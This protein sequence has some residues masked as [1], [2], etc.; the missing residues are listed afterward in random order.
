MESLTVTN[1][2]GY[3]WD[4]LDVETKKYLYNTEQL[5]SLSQSSKTLQ[6]FQPCTLELGII[7]VNLYAE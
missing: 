3:F 5:Y 2:K 1:A 6:W 4:A 7:W